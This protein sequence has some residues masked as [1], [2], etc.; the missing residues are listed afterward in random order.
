MHNERGEEEKVT[1][2]ERGKEKRGRERYNVYTIT[3]KLVMEEMQIC[4]P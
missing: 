1:E 2:S 4:F 3:A